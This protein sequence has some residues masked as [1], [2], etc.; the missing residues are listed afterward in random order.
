M[1]S[2]PSLNILLFQFDSCLLLN[3]LYFQIYYNLSL[4]QLHFK[5]VGVTLEITHIDSEFDYVTANYWCYLDILYYEMGFGLYLHLN[6]SKS[7]NL[8]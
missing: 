5:I 1:D 7:V 4:N 8:A 6:E 3:D 2:N